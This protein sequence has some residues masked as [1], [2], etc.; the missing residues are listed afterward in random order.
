MMATVG[1]GDLQ[2]LSR[3]CPECRPHADRCLQGWGLWMLRCFPHFSFYP[4]CSETDTSRQDTGHVRTVVSTKV[5]SLQYPRLEYSMERGAWCTIVHGYYF[6]LTFNYR[7]LI[8][9]ASPR[10]WG[11]QGTSIF[12]LISYRSPLWLAVSPSPD[13]ILKLI[14]NCVRLPT[15]ISYHYRGK[16]NHGLQR[17]LI[18][19]RNCSGFPDDTG[20][21]EPACECRRHRGFR[22][23]PWAGKTPWSWRWQPT[24]VFLPEKFQGQRRRVGYSSWG[25][26][27]SDTTEHASREEPLCRST[28][29]YSEVLMNLV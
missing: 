4:E 29:V 15:T 22:F 11:L 3:L 25:H 19:L 8:M 21:K 6:T 1:C 12:A 24:A 20:G 16:V 13:V 28:K 7:F 14:Y 23:D 5:N 9:R 27:E 17:L 2:L 10:E 26:K 18:M